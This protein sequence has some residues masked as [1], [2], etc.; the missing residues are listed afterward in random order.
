M[1]RRWAPH[2][3]IEIAEPPISER[4]DRTA[5]TPNRSFDF[6]FGMSSKSSGC[7]DRHVAVG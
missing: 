6:R 2:G 5:W 4:I 1:G 3:P 7:R